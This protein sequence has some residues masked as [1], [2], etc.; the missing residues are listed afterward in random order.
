[1]KIKN[2]F[3]LSC[4][5]AAVTFTACDKDDDIKLND[6]DRNFM[7]QA[8][9]SNLAEIEAG[10][11]ASTMGQK[12][13]VKKYGAMMVMEHQPAYNSLDSIAKL[14][15][16]TIPTT[17]DAENAAIKQRLMTYTGRTFDTAY[18]NSQ[19]AGHQKT[20]NL[21]QNEI[22]NGSDEGLRSYATKLIPHIQE[23]FATANT[24]KGKL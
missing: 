8:A 18:I 6:T 21:F 22:A 10:Q 11:L 5:A 2:L 7:T 19:I 14:R 17:V 15:S 20:I 16:V 3:Y 9:I 24:I 4:L 1:M 23:H 12:D 13:S